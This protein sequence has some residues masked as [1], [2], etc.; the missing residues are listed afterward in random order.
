MNDP[1]TYQAV[2]IGDISD[3]RLIVAI[4]AVGMGAWLKNDDPMRDVETL[5]SETWN[6]PEED[7]LKNIENAVYDH[8]QVLDDFS[9]DIAIIAPKS[10]WAPADLVEENEDE[11][12]RIYN[13]VYTADE[14]DILT[15][16]VADATC[17]F[18]LTPGLNAFLQRTFPGAR[19]HSHLGVLTQ[20]FRERSADMPRV[21]LDIRNKE[22]DIIA[23]DR[24]N[25]LMAATHSWYSPNDIQYHLFNILNV[26]GLNPEEVQVSLSGLKDVKAELLPLLRKTIAYV[27]LTMTSAPGAKA[28][29]PL[30]ASLLLRK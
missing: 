5:V 16:D 3:W 18:S 29:M 11:I 22:V 17:I 20:R 24:K 19:I 15:E 7:I 6:C 14:S 25:L 13:Q 10:I 28:E 4:S 9:S 27:M 2:K 30:A 1:N 12:L 26:Y 8:P 23:F 21:Y